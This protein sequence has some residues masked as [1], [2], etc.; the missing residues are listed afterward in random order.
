[1]GLFVAVLLF[2]VL[3][4][5]DAR[6]PVA[7]AVAVILGTVVA[8]GFGSAWM[9]G[10]VVPDPEPRPLDS[11]AW[12]T[13]PWVRWGMA[14]YLLESGELLGLRREEVWSLLGYGDGSYSDPVTADTDWETWKVARPR[15]MLLVASPE[16]V[17]DYDRR[18]HVSRAW[19]EPAT[20][21]ID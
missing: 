3:A 15:D 21:P 19:I 12:Q 14:Q 6:R 10:L 9:A 11:G 17:V 4:T 20:L 8:V 1:M 16:L 2:R 7:L 18:G 5:M 13:R